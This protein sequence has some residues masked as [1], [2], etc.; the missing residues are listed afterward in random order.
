MQAF[1]LE[2]E[3]RFSSLDFRSSASGQE[4]GTGPREA[5]DKVSRSISHYRI[6]TLPVKRGVKVI[7]D[8]HERNEAICYV[9]DPS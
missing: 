9:G 1:D 3:P 8:V 4:A 5:R 2:L 7:G 6:L